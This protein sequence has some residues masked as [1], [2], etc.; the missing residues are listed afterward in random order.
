[1][2]SGIT[3]IL[4]IFADRDAV[5]A[6]AIAEAKEYG[7][8]QSIA[9]EVSIQSMKNGRLTSGQM[10]GRLFKK[11]T[12]SARQQGEAR[13]MFE[14]MVH[15]A[16]RKL[17]EAERKTLGTQSAEDRVEELAKELFHRPG[18]MLTNE[19][20]TLM[21]QE[22][23]CSN[24]RPI[25][26]CRYPIAWLYRSIDGTCNNLQNP[27]FGASETPF[28]R[29]VPP[30]YEDGIDSL[31]GDLQALQNELFPLGPFLPPIPSARHISK[32][33]I[34]NDVDDME[35]PFTHTLMQWGQFLDHDLDLSPELEAQCIGCVF[36]KFCRPIRVQAQDPV[37]GENTKQNGECLRFARSLPACDL[38]VPGTM[39]PREQ[40]NAITSFIDASQVY[41]S[42]EIVGKAVRAFVN[43][44][45]KEGP[46]F[47][48]NLPS[49]PI[50]DDD[51]VACLNAEECFLAGDVRANE[52]ISLTIMHTLWF[53]EHNRIAREL[54]RINP[55]WNDER[56]FQEARKIVGALIQK[57]TYVDYLP[58]V[59]G[60]TTF[61]QVIGPFIEYDPRVNPGVP[62]GFA[63][64][65][66]RYGHSLVRPEFARLDSSF[67]PIAKGPLNLVDAFFNPDQFRKSLGTDPIVRGWIS[68][69]SLRADS[70]INKVL[71]TQ[72]FE[73]K[74]EGIIGMDLAALNIQR[75]RD[76]GLPPFLLWV[77]RCRRQ[78]PNLGGFGQIQRDIDFLNFVRLYGSLSDVD[79]WIG[80]LAEQRLPESFIG[81]TFACIFGIT[82]SN[83]RD[84]DRFWYENPGIFTP[85]QLN[86]IK[87][88][89]LSRVIC[90][91]SDNIDEIQPDAFLSNQ[92]RIDCARIPSVDLE[93]WKENGCFARVLVMPLPFDLEITAFSRAI[94]TDTVSTFIQ[95]FA[96][97]REFPSQCMSIACP[98]KSYGTIVLIESDMPANIQMVP[99]SNL[100]TNGFSM[101]NRY[102]AVWPKE[103]FRRPEYGVFM[104]EAACQNSPNSVAIN[105]T[106]GA[107][108][109]PQQNDDQNDMEEEL[110]NL[111]HDNKPPNSVGSK[112]ESDNEMS[113]MSDEDLMAQLEQALHDLAL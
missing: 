74:T 40:L 94:G 6:Q 62:N 36:T 12:K 2:S 54:K 102:W 111:F 35:T 78:F 33:V 17:A 77:N 81:P 23:G 52:Q 61:D 37:F 34:F 38:D 58:K 18:S 106:I 110:D 85:D 7:R 101:D 48:G 31:R 100:P 4:I 56:L 49:L 60:P 3:C 98:I 105:V 99:N 22:A 104:S 92:S 86:E 75:G 15:R 84:G 47:P 73:N 70:I 27:L 57:I 93:L 11:A 88:G 5:I 64:A 32:T 8:Q 109:Q 20:L 46:N 107:P 72:L 28:I 68:E 50:D 41:G 103:A 13:V 82:F 44:L 113:E 9:R 76:H 16:E 25:P 89:T 24:I 53:R 91:N 71:L 45:L 67:R 21:N 1:M 66:Y 59:L 10:V 42:N 30:L 63:T 39:P 83:V 80:G 96:T 14:D 79:L 29:I 108:V 65:A 95:M 26:V 69:E 51:I 97:T 19:E 112:E 90:D 55:F 87:Q 43:G